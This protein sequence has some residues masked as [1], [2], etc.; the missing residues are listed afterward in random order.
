[1][2]LFRCSSCGGAFHSSRFNPIGEALDDHCP[3]G[4]GGY[5]IRAASANVQRPFQEHFNHAL[6]VPVRTR[7]EFYDATRRAEEHQF[8]MLGGNPH[9]V[10]VDPTDTKGLGVDGAGLEETARARRDLILP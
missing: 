2:Y 10:E 5:L 1:M 7:G 8:N 4:D 9:F 6:G 3:G